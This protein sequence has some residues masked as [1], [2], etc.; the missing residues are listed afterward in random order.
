[1][2]R[3]GAVQSGMHSWMGRCAKRTVDV[4]LGGAM[5]LL[6][7]VPL[8]LAALAI[9]LED[10]GEVIFR[11]QRVGRDGKLFRIFKLR[12]MTVMREAPSGPDRLHRDDARITRVGNVLRKVGLDELPQLFNV[13]SGAMSL[14]GPR[15]TLEF[16]VAQYDDFQRRRLE[17]KPGITSLAV[18]SGRNAL[19]WTE[20]IKLDVWY[21][22]H[23]SLRLDLSILFR[24]LWKVLI[25]REGLYATDGF[26]DGFVPPSD[27]TD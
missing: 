24:T 5:I 14:V 17:A 12:T 7:S 25:T 19:S 16:Q 27:A 9:K 4:V 22:D 13:L 2:I 8:A 10:G 21:I 26:N 1:V 20:R 15:P 11:Q 6:S 18:V 23:W 3:R